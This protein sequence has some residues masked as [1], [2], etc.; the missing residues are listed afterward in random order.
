MA[1]ALLQMRDWKCVVLSGPA[2]LFRDWIMCGTEW[3][4]HLLSRDWIMCSTE[5][6][7]NV[8]VL[9]GSALLS[10]GLDNVWY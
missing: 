8:P 7:D 10:R 9:R 5:G 1:G 6:L 4:Q 3:P 2:L